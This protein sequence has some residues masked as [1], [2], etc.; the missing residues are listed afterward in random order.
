LQALC[1]VSAKDSSAGHFQLLEQLGYSPYWAPG[2]KIG[3]LEPE[4][5]YLLS[6]EYLRV[7]NSV[8]RPPECHIGDRVLRAGGSAFPLHCFVRLQAVLLFQPQQ[9][10]QDS[11]LPAQV[12]QAFAA[13]QVFVVFGPNLVSLGHMNSGQKE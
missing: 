8:V 11:C 10:E 12:V 4:P 6:A 7:Q 1:F 2:W 13:E 5:D 3:A 9:A